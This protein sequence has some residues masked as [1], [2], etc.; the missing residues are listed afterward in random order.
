MN[1]QLRKHK[2]LEIL[3]ARGSAEV[4]HLAVELGISEITVRRDLNVLAKESSLL[5]THGGAVKLDYHKPKISFSAKSEQNA[6][7]KEEIALK[8]AGLIEEG[9][10]VFLDCGST[11]FRM[12][13]H[14][15]NK[16]IR[17]VTNSI[18]VL[19]ELLGSQVS[20]NLV[21]GEIDHE[22]QA[23]HGLTA[24]EHICRYRIDKG[25]VGVDGI[26]LANGLSAN[27]EKEAEI[28]L[29]VAAHAKETY[30]L[31]DASKFETEKYFQFADISLVKNIVVESTIS[32]DLKNAYEAFGIR[33]L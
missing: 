11:V 23:A 1:F 7:A 22:R 27:S 5:R 13:K 10:I 31:C 17:V 28:T 6:E 24:V 9:D 33:V 12:C 20:I 14:L 21:G 32:A 25:F 16:K 2:I 8:A 26:S 19:N 4:P 18:P 15:K 30:F 3:E 29:A